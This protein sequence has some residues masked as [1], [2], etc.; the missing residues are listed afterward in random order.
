MK[1]LLI[2]LFLFS[3]HSFSG[4][5]D[6]KGLDCVITRYDN[7]IYKHMIWFNYG[8]YQG[9]SVYYS[10]IYKEFSYYPINK[11][12]E[13]PPNREY[14]STA[15]QLIM[16]TYNF[17]YGEVQTIINRKTLDI[18]ITWKESDG[19]ERIN[20]GNCKVIGWEEV[21]KRQEKLKEEI[22]E[23]QR[24]EKEKYDKAREG[25]KI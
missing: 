20:R 10:D 16:N 17:Y 13:C 12:L 11:T 9:V 2:L 18:K 3:S 22:I 23:K 25:N 14:R 7:Y 6:G 24:I 4:E 15:D 21:K 1:Y 8:C 19:E 5:V